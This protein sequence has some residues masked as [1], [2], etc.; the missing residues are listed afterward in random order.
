MFE[1]QLQSVVLSDRYEVKGPISSGSYAEGFVAR[2]RDGG[3]NVVIK[4]LNTR[5]QGLPSPELE[6]MLIEKFA[7]EAAILDRIRHPS[8]ISS[9]DRGNG[10]DRLGRE[11]S[12]IVL[13]FMAGRRFDGAQPNERIF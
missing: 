11:F 2:D 4:A 13:E 1:L 10:E 3:N 6:Q 9:R 5:L 12:F 8:I 7:N